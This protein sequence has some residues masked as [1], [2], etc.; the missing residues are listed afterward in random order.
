[1]TRAGRV[2]DDASFRAARPA[3]APVAGAEGDVNAKRLT[4]IV[5]AIALSGCAAAGPRYADHIGT[6][7]D[8]PPHLTRLTVFRTA[9]S[10]QYSGRSAAVRIDGVDRGGCEFAGYQTFHVPAGPHVLAVEMWDAPGSCSLS[11][12]TLGGEEYFFEISPRTESSVAYLLGSMIGAGTMIGAIAP[13]AVMGAESA[14]SKCGGAF[15]IVEVDE[16]IARR[17]LGDLRLSK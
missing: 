15:S 17:K 11:I 7:P 9:E 6:F 5:L 13:F 12:D 4:S 1:M 16:S 3:A 14:G 10:T 2:V 8:V